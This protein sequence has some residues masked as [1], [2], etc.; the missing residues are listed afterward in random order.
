M[1]RMHNPPY[2]GETLR[3]DVLPALGL[4]VTKAAEAL[5][6]TR[7][8]LSRLLNGAAGVSPKMALRIPNAPQCRVVRQWLGRTQHHRPTSPRCECARG[9]SEKICSNVR[10][11]RTGISTT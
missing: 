11:R 9:E 2:P 10:S 5:G 1:T 6:V 8:T 3:V 7:V 4:N